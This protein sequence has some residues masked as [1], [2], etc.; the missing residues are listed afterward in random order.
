MEI[1]FKIIYIHSITQQHLYFQ[2]SK[3]MQRQTTETIYWYFS[4]KLKCQYFKISA[5]RVNAG[6]QLCALLA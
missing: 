3:L 2:I 5:C 1:A 4:L 6:P